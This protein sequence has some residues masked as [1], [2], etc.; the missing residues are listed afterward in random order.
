MNAGGKSKGK[1][2]TFAK[3]LLHADWFIHNLMF[4]LHNIPAVLQ[5]TDK[6]IKAQKVQ[7]LWSYR[8]QLLWG[9]NLGLWDSKGHAHSTVPG[10]LLAPWEP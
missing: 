6:E 1:W 3:N 8:C 2:L 7:S 9:F 4:S 10:Y 5:F